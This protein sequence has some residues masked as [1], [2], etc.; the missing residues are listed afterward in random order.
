M[1]E[2]VFSAIEVLGNYIYFRT[3][4]KIFILFETQKDGVLVIHE[5]NQKEYKIWYTKGTTKKILHSCKPR[6]KI[7][8]AVSSLGNYIK[9]K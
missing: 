5:T 4:L 3:R 2:W 7:S 8:S 1:P 9:T 6:R